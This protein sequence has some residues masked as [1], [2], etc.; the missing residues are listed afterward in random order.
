MPYPP[1]HREATKTRILRSAQALFNRRG[2]EGVSID[3]IMAHAGLTHGGFYSYFRTKADLYAETVS[4]GLKTVARLRQLEP[5]AADVSTD[6]NVE[7]AQKI[8]RAY[9]SRQHFDDLEGSCPLAA[10][11]GDVLRSDPI[12]KQA[13]EAVFLS[14]VETFERGLMNGGQPDRARALAIASLCVGGMVVARSLKD[15]ALADDLRHAA[16]SAAFHI[17]SW[18][19]SS[20]RNGRFTKP[21]GDSEVELAQSNSA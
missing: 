8:A 13:F 3:E 15:G 4:L 16:L 14:L 2:F 17:G 9:L 6:A 7:A 5:A 20:A 10:L 18:S 19:Q 11:P 12:V 21:S 1:E